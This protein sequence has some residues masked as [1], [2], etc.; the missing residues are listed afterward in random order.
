MNHRCAH[1]KVYRDERIREKDHGLA[2]LYNDRRIYPLLSALTA[3]LLL[4][5]DS[6]TLVRN[7]YF[8]D[9]PRERIFHLYFS[10]P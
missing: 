4:P 1:A 5:L 3:A 9:L 7:L 6:S 2:I 8:V 10:I